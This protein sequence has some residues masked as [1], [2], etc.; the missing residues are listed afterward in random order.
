M[1]AFCWLVAPTSLPLPRLSC[2]FL[3]HPEGCVSRIKRHKYEEPAS[4]PSIHGRYLT[5]YSFGKL[6]CSQLF[7]QIYCLALGKICLFLSLLLYVFIMFNY[8]QS[9]N[10]LSLCAIV[11]R[12]C[13]ALISWTRAFG[14]F[15][16][17]KYLLLSASMS[18]AHK[19]YSL[20]RSSRGERESDVS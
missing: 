13:E 11:P 19:F 1:V 3:I 15:P 9:R 20:L 16:N 17:I 6:F 8:K 14:Y 7:L 10:C 18:L 12:S 5:P 2:P 4:F